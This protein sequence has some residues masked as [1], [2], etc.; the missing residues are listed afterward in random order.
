MELCVEI[1]LPALVAVGSSAATAGRASDSARPTARSLC[2]GNLRFDIAEYTDPQP[3]PESQI[4]DGTG[5]M[6]YSMLRGRRKEIIW[7]CRRSTIG[8]TGTRPG[9]I[10]PAAPASRCRSSTCP[11]GR[12]RQRPCWRAAVAWSWRSA[13]RVPRRSERRAA[14]RFEK[15]LVLCVAARPVGREARIACGNALEA[16]DIVG[17]GAPRHRGRIDAV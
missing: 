6:R 8:S 9:R 11:L 12:H 15:G 4:R 2:T 10:A 13:E 7:R 3:E 1:V 17:V 16:S 14:V 5:A